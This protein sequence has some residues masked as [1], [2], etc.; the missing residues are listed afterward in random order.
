VDRQDNP[1]LLGLQGLL[2]NQDLKDPREALVH[3]G[4]LDFQEVKAPRVN[5]GLAAPQVLQDLWV[6]EDLP[7]TADLKDPQDLKETLD[8]P[9][10]PVPLEHQVLQAHLVRQ[11]RLDNRD[12]QDLRALLDHREH[13]G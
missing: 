13:P 10:L 2:G 5:K 6:R 12:L 9:D 3:L 4:Q 7:A 8:L 1:D 11:V